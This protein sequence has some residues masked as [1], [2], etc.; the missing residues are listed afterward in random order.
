MGQLYGDFSDMTHEWTD[1]I[2]AS[3]IKYFNNIFLILEKLLK[4]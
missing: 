2:L 1:G 3:I 4:T